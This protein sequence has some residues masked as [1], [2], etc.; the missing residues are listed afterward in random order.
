MNNSEKSIFVTVVAWIFIVIS[1]F[2]TVVGALQNIA[3]RFIFP[4]EAMTEALDQAQ[5]QGEI[6][7][8]HQFMFQSID[9]FFLGFFLVAVAVLIS[10]I[11]LLRRKN[12]ARI[13]FIV[14]MGLGIVWNLAGLAFTFLFM[15]H[16]PGPEVQEGPVELEA[17]MNMILGMNILFVVV[18]SVL[19]GWIIKKLVSPAIRREFV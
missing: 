15:D 8:M 7:G 9:I 13:I 14:L 3:I 16:M 17:M 6:S 5:T 10:S 18:F 19:F 2:V 4:R 11:G 12:W 1:G